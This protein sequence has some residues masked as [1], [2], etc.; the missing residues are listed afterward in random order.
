MTREHHPTVSAVLTLPLPQN[1]VAREVSK[2]PI[3]L[4]SVYDLLPNKPNTQRK[5]YPN[6]KY[7]HPTIH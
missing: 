5:N 3:R 6:Y 1:M 7:V 2:V 4:S